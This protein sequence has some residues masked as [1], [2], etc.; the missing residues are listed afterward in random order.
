VAA[1]LLDGDLR[2]LTFHRDGGAPA[3]GSS[4]NDY[5]DLL[6]Y[7]D[8]L[9]ADWVKAASRIGPRVLVDLLAVTGP[10]VAAF[11]AS[12]DPHG[13]AVFP[14]AWAGEAESRNWMDTGRE[15]TERWHH[16]QQIREA[17]GAPLLT[18]PEWLRPVFDV[19][20]RALPRACRGTPAERGQAVAFAIEGP[21][22]SQWAVVR[23]DAGW[24]LFGGRP[25]RP[26]AAVCLDED[27]AWRGFFKALPR[28]E[29]R[30]RARVEGDAALAE[31]LLG[32]LAVMA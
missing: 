21:A 8:G 9:N 31:P 27:T 5:A 10:Q 15:Y 2:K 26:A 13:R 30:R 22:G 24:E 28:E 6:A 19:S 12:L 7:L 14:V 4:L 20:V 11:V 25:E 18:S 32:V 3:A 23:Q 29:M 1:H 17:V 16:Q